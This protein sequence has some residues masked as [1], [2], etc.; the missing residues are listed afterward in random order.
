MEST[1]VENASH[2][3]MEA[4]TPA[5]VKTSATEAATM[6]TATTK[7]TTVAAARAAAHT[8]TSVAATTATSAATRQCHCRRSQA[9][10]RDC[11]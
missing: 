9:N 6:E 3:G 5:T 1:A 4:A 7:A 8:A 11:Q 2:P 10:G